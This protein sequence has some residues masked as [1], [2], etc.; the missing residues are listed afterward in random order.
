VT[1]RVTLR[2]HQIDLSRREF[3]LLCA[4]ATE[5]QRVFTKAQLLRSLWEPTAPVGTSRTLDS[6]AVRLRHKFAVDGDRFVVNVW[7]VGYALQRDREGVSTHRAVRA[8][9]GP[10][11]RSSAHTRWCSSWRRRTGGGVT[12][13]L[14][15]LWGARGDAQRE[16]RAHSG[17]TA[18]TPSSSGRSAPAAACSPR[19]GRFA[20]A[21]HDMPPARSSPRR[22]ISTMSE[23]ADM[24]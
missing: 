15:C 24:R 8:S 21:C 17:F 19:A 11:N 9:K 20:G 5:P 23:L 10:A 2:E 22:R 7:G 18:A 6:H 1:R 16:Q 14:H 3:A 12:F 4:L 13:A